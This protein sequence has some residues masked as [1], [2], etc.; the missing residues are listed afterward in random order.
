MTKSLLT[1]WLC[2][3]GISLLASAGTGG[4]SQKNIPHLHPLVRQFYEAYVD[5]VQ[6][7]NETM[8]TYKFKDPTEAYIT[9]YN[10]KISFA[11]KKEAAKRLQYLSDELTK[12]VGKDKTVQDDLIR[13]AEGPNPWL[14]YAR[15]DLPDRGFVG[16]LELE[17]HIA[18]R[19]L[20]ILKEAGSQ[21]VRH[22]PTVKEIRTKQRQAIAEH[23][24]FEQDRGYKLHQ[25]ITDKE[26]GNLLVSIGGGIAE[27]ALL[28]LYEEP[29]S[30]KYPNISPYFAKNLV[31]LMGDRA[32]PYL[33]K[34]YD[35]TG[36][37]RTYPSLDFLF[38]M[39]ESSPTEALPLLVENVENR[40]MYPSARK[41]I[42]QVMQTVGYKA[43]ERKEYLA[44]LKKISEERNPFFFGGRDY[45]EHEDLHKYVVSLLEK[46]TGR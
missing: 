46:E 40:S 29:M 37:G 14:V 28:E 5:F 3:V 36:G 17:D 42:V 13:V 2:T 26:V 11:H 22:I 25:Y 23:S 32:F 1:V 27:A 4:I 18:E 38:L 44:T 7:S 39:A 34:A 9:R 8:L 41:Q 12:I 24:T 31:V 43:A 21:L 35:K 19:S 45:D 20:E 30:S 16:Y 6:E 10:D 15:H 33:K